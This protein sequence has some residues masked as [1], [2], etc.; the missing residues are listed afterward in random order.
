LETNVVYAG[1]VLI[2]IGLVALAVHFL[3]KTI[4]NVSSI[5]KML[6]DH[7]KVLGEQDVKPAQFKPNLS[8]I[9]FT[10]IQMNIGD[11]TLLVHCFY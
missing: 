2:K 7:I 9:F 8:Y 5:W 4:F 3:L 6:V 1:Y 11:L 10:E